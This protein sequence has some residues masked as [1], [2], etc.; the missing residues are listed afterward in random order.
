LGRSQMDKLDKF[1]ITK[2]FILLLVP[3]SPVTALIG[4]LK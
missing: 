1:W 3:T 2:E 4:R